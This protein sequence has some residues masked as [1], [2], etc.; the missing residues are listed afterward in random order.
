MTSTEIPTTY[1]QLLVGD[2]IHFENRS[3]EVKYLAGQGNVWTVA[4]T[5]TDRRHNL[6]RACTDR[7][8]RQAR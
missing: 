6:M 5:Q 1:G 2:I 4:D 3:Y 8:M 7:V